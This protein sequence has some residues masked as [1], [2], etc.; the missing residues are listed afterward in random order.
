MPH[1]YGQRA[2]TRQM[3]SRDFRQR[4]RLP[5]STYLKLYR[6]GD[7]VD[8]KAD[9]AIQKGMPNKVYHGRTGR[10]WNVAKNSVGVEINKRVGNRILKKR[11]TVRTEHIRHSRSREDFLRRVRANDKLKAEAKKKGEKY[12]STKRQVELPAGSY[13][14]NMKTATVENMEVKPYIFMV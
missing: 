7:L 8:V 4:G 2:R 13:T 5:L 12:P 1:S 9:P 6:V 11:V 10:V 14:V 3:F